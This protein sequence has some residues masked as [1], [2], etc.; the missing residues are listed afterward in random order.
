MVI[1]VSQAMISFI[2]DVNGCHWL[3]CPSPPW[4]EDFNLRII[5]NKQPANKVD[6]DQGNSSHDK[7]IIDVNCRSPPRIQDF[8]LRTI[9]NKQLANKV[10]GDQGNSSHD[11][12]IIDM[13]LVSLASLP[14]TPKNPRL[15][16]KN[17]CNKQPANKVDDD[18]DSSSNDK[19]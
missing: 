8:S 7:L 6:G 15:Q 4:I 19:F 1:R 13:N 10:D 12:L 2:V 18:Q 16:F 5:D 3:H 11:K 14:I 17:N 9:D